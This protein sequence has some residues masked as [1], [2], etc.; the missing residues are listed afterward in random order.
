MLELYLTFINKSR[1]F[2]ENHNNGDDNNNNIFSNYELLDSSGMK[3]GD[4]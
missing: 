1:I 2:S 4:N 3:S